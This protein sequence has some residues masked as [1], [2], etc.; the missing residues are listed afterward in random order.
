LTPNGRQIWKQGIVPDVKI[1]LPADAKL[2]TPRLLS[3]M[4][5]DQVHSSGDPQLLKA[6]ELL[7]QR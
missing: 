4:T 7:G 1:D 6:L 2:M 5:P 3:E